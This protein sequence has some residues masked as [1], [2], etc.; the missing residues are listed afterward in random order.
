MLSLGAKV[1]INTALQLMKTS[2]ICSLAL[3]RGAALSSSYE[4]LGLR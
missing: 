4:E 1:A 3:A 2:W